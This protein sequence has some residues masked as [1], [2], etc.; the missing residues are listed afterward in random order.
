MV[1]VDPSSPAP[2]SPSHRPQIRGWSGARALWSR[3]AATVTK[4][5]GWE[6]VRGQWDTAHDSLNAS[7]PSGGSRDA[8][9]RNDDGGSRPPLRAIIAARAA[10]EPAGP[11]WLRASSWPRCERRWEGRSRSTPT[12][13]RLRGVG[14]ATILHERNKL[15]G[16]KAGQ[17]SRLAHPTRWCIESR[18][19]GI[20]SCKRVCRY[21]PCCAAI[22]GASEVLRR[23][24]GHGS[25]P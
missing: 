8:P 5:G 4:S 19:R 16:N 7:L 9:S 25:A 20:Y 13:D 1:E 15:D 6:V 21:G 23:P 17:A 18:D 11:P 3:R 24:R 10:G 12:A 2:S 14:G 22:R